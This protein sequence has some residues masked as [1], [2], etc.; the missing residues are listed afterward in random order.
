MNYQIKSNLPIS[1]SHWGLV[2]RDGVAVTEDSRLAGR[3]KE[4]GYEV[5]EIVGDSVFADVPTKFVEP[6]IIDTPTLLTDVS[7]M[8]ASKEVSEPEKFTCPKCGKEY[9][10]ETSFNK[11]VEKCEVE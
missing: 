6:I 4:R 9:K 8:P 5:S 11:H 7:V 3:L 10:N 1:G 2:F